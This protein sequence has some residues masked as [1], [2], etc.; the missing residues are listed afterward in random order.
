MAK[1]LGVRGS[2]PARLLIKAGSAGLKVIDPRRTAAAADADAAVARLTAPSAAVADII[3]QYVF[4]ESLAGRWQYITRIW[5]GVTNI[6]SAYTC[7]KTGNTATP[8]ATFGWSADKGVVI[9]YNVGGPDA[10]I[11]LNYNASADFANISDLACGNVVSKVLWQG[12]VSA[13]ADT[14]FCTQSGFPSVVQTYKNPPASP[15]K[16]A[17]LNGSTALISGTDAELRNK[18]IRIDSTAAGIPRIRL[19]ALEGVGTFPPFVSD[20]PDACQ[21][22]VLLNGDSVGM[23]WKMAYFA[24]AD[25]AW[26]G[27]RDNTQNMIDSLRAL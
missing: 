2:N 7:L 25:L 14:L 4:N 9:P 21:I 22:G 24:T 27:F 18:V 11:A 3:Y 26:P 20:V 19:S 23:D 10:H 5:V 17:N 1:F 6:A 16:Q 15:Q 13:G 8:T 12:S